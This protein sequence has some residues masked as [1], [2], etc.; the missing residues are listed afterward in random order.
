[1]S[2]NLDE[3][4]YCDEIFKD[5]DLSHQT[6]LGIEFDGC[7]FKN[8][9]FNHTILDFSKFL[10]CHFEYCDLSLV[11][12]KGS[13]FNDVQFLESKV[14][15]VN[16][17]ATTAPFE[18]NF[19]R[20]DISMSSFYTLDLRRAMITGS[21]AHDV[22]FV[23]TNLEKASFKGTDL[24]GSSFGDTNL[25]GADLSQASNYMIDPNKNSLK[26]TKV[27]LPEAGS[28]LHYFDLKIIT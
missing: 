12:V 26:Q 23:R 27:S 6:L 10:E 7:T 18:I 21:K 13:L 28:F 20:C 25:K 11:K 22:D 15:G 16:W 14:I 4:L 9:L 8:C 2:D 19:D 17:S 24:A 5:L 3:E 1:M